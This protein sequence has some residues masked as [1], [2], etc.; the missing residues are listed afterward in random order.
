[1]YLLRSK[2]NLKRNK[3]LNHRASLRVGLFNV[4]REK[5]Q[6]LNDD[7]ETILGWFLR[8]ERYMPVIS[9]TDLSEL[10]QTRDQL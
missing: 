5:T 3:H 7:Y 4:I 10:D 8:Y 6:S 1:M 9:P 2:L